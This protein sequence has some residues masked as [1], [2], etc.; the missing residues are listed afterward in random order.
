MLGSLIGEDAGLM[1]QRLQVQILPEQIPNNTSVNCKKVVV[2]SLEN[3]VG[4]SH[5]RWG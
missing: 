3:D 2:F 5:L 4:R 1:S